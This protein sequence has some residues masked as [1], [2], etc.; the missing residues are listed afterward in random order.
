MNT[1]LLLIEIWKVL[2]C[3]CGIYYVGIAL[4]S[5]DAKYHI[6]DKED[7]L[8]TKIINYFNGNK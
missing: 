2:V 7:K 6:L 4:S 5:I 8:R 1:V 3:I